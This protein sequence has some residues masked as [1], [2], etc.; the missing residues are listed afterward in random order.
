MIIVGTMPYDSSSTLTDAVRRRSGRKG[1][2][3][4]V[5]GIRKNPPRESGIF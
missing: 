1:D 4:K 2:L 5:I 3:R